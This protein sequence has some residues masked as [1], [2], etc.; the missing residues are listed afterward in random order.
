MK[1]S[2]CERL[3]EEAD[4]ASKHSIEIAA[5]IFEDAAKCFD[6]KS[7]REKAGKF[8]TLAGDFF[9][10]LNMVNKA[11][12]CYGKAIV[13]Y[14]M[15]DNLEMAQLLLEKG[16]EYGFSSSTH[17]FRIAIDTLERREKEEIKEEIEIE[18]EILV[19][20]TL[21]DIEIMPIGEDDEIEA[22]IAIDS[23][24]FNPD[25]EV[26]IKKE[27]Y[28]VPQLDTDESS[29]LSSFS[30]LAAVSQSTRKRKKPDIHTN[31]VV[32]DKTGSSRFIQPTQILT[33][34]ETSDNSGDL[35]RDPSV[36]KELSQEISE[37]GFRKD[38]V[39]VSDVLTRNDTLD[40][41]YAAKTELINEYEE[42]LIDIEIIDTIPFQWQVV[43]VKSDFELDERQSTSEGL[44]FTW[45]KGKIDPGSKVSVEYILRKRIAR[46]IIL[47]KKNQVSVVSLYHS[48]KQDL[49][50]QLDF[51][52][53]SGEVFRDVLVEDI[54]PPELIVK[55]AGSSQEIKPIFIP[56]HDSTLYR[57]IFSDLIPGDI[58]SVNYK[59]R[60]KP[61]TR[62]Y[63]DEIEIDDRVI[64]I[65]KISQPLIDSYQYDYIWM[66]SIDNQV[67]EDF[68]LF[69][70]IPA[71]FDLIL[72]DPIHL[73]PSITKDNTQKLLSWQISSEEKNI[74]IIIRIRGT[75]SFTPIAPLL[76]FPHI[77]GEIQLK[78]RKATSEKRLIDIRRLL[79]DRKEND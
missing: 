52:N 61:L 2:D 60:E 33:P 56:T 28:F 44:I 53:T 79:K 67:I 31:A 66:Y 72:V 3:I 16:K 22:L 40:L 18:E 62:Y 47:R 17:Q 59:F 19:P 70:R 15:I 6:G 37:K 30:V 55:E 24:M 50:E 65:E 27:D 34:L 57:W 71:D 29:K 23:E 43:D 41:D 74:S 36:Q 38:E 54:I 10:D 7:E 51:V 58:F 1:L 4:E 73:R 39:I 5:D 20:E 63:I 68:T 35:T 11:A 42:E 26:Q 13:R 8:L 69:D 21:P 25:N 14:L 76:E 64:K 46:S 12:I 32:K 45:K 9:L 78:E 77:N 49:E 48:I 75:E